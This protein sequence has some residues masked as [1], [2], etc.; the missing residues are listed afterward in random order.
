M[1]C[2]HVMAPLRLNRKPLLLPLREGPPLLQRQIK[3]GL[4]QTVTMLQIF[5]NLTARLSY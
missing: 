3:T 2:H 4:L 5:C 1:H